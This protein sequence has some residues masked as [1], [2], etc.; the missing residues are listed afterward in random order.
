MSRRKSVTHFVAVND[1]E[2]PPSKQEG[3]LIEVPKK[4]GDIPSNREQA[5]QIVLN[6]WEKGEIEPDLFPNGLSDENIFY[7]PPDSP[8]LQKSETQKE[9]APIP[10]IVEGAQEIIQLTKLQLE[11]QQAAEEAAPYVPIIEAVLSGTRPLNSSER[12]IARDKKY[13]KTI[14]KLGEM[15]ASQSDYRESCTGN[16]KL[17]L[18]AIRWQCEQGIKAELESQSIDADQVEK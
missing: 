15:V 2:Q 13:A 5:L 16:G 14:S 17:I 10:P 9:S 12:E 7:V 1:L 11:V 4:G 3:L 18:N 6:K 8:R